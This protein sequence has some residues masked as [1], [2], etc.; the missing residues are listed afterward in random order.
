MVISCFVINALA[1]EPKYKA[2]AIA[3]VRRDLVTIYAVTCIVAIAAA[4]D[5]ESFVWLFVFSVEIGN[6]FLTQ[7]LLNFFAC[8]LL[9]ATIRTRFMA[10]RAWRLFPVCAM[11]MARATPVTFMVR[12]GISGRRSGRGR[13][14]AGELRHTLYFRQSV[15]LIY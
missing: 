1:G 8:L 11:T 5:D 12:A 6:S 14:E 3:M 9:T 7:A 15:L 10:T 2:I 4:V 13:L